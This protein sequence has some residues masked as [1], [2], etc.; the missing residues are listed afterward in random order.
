MDTT[1]TWHHLPLSFNRGPYRAGTGVYRGRRP[2]KVGADP[3]LANQVCTGLRFV[4]WQQWRCR[5]GECHEFLQRSQGTIANS[6][7]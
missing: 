4:D 1:F 7:S 3:A 5:A 6:H 2:L